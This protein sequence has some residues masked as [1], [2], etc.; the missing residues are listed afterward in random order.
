MNIRACCEHATENEYHYRYV[1]SRF[2]ILQRDTFI[3]KLKYIGQEELSAVQ[4]VTKG[5]NT[6]KCRQSSVPVAPSAVPV[7]G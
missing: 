7:A 1:V 2:R 5:V 6:F 4:D 3:S